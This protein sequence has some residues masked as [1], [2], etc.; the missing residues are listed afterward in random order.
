MVSSLPG[1]TGK[2]NRDVSDSSS[3]NKQQKKDILERFVGS[4]GITGS[5]GFGSGAE[6]E[7]P[8]GLAEKLTK[9]I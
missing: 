9:K 1:P 7:P 6:T 4:V 3:R 2:S 5:L 8:S